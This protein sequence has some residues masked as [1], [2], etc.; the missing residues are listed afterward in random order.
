MKKGG[1]EEDQNKKTEKIQKCQR[2]HGKSI[3]VNENRVRKK[4]KRQ[5]DRRARE[6]M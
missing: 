1:G 4:R 5:R 6:R 2:W 3:E